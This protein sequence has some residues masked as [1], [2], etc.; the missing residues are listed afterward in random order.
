MPGESRMSRVL[1]TC[2]EACDR[3]DGWLQYWPI[4]GLTVLGLV[5]AFGAALLRS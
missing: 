1:R 3:F 2:G 4:A 5:V